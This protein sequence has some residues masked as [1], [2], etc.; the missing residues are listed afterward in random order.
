MTLA[1]AVNCQLVVLC[2]LRAQT[3]EVN[4]LLALRNFTQAMHYQTC[5]RLHSSEAQPR[6]LQSSQSGSPDSC[7]NPNGDLSTKRN[8]G[9]LLAR[10]VG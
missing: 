8:I 7:V 5:G 2:S 6:H 4:E 3:A 10:M 9:L 1:R